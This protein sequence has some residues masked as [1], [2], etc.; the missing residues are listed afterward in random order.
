[1]SDA[2]LSNRL[3]QRVSAALEKIE[4]EPA[5][6][7]EVEEAAE[8]TEAA[9]SAAVETASPPAVEDPKA[10]RLAKLA[11][12]E[13][14][15]VEKRQ[16]SSAREQALEAREARL[17]ALEQ[18]I[19]A[20]DKVWDDPISL[21]D[22]LE[23]K[24]GPEKLVDYLSKA[25]DPAQVAA[26]T[27]REARKEIDP[28]IAELRAKVQ[29]IEHQEIQAKV[30]TQFK[31]IIAENAASEAQFTARALAKNEAAV[32]KR[33]DRIADHLTA[34]K[35]NY[36]LYTIAVLLEQ[37]LRESAELTAEKPEATSK[38]APK[39]ALGPNTI[40]NRDA[41]TRTTVAANGG[42]RLSYEER[43]AKA[44]R[45]AREQGHTQ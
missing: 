32:L 25:K 5:A 6:P 35:Q 14:D 3:D 45:A 18:Q 37:E 26:R 24:V 36:N 15:Q 13:R 41:S 33:A 4:A 16:Q 29:R 2:E 38:E 28:E 20:R 9:A 34:T 1:M 8:E 27:A 31:G 40:S 7:A 17:A 19:A 23:Q 43:I 21:L 10:G 30:Y 22:M 12:L 39:E 44:E 11:K 42:K